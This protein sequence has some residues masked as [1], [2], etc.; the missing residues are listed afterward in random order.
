MKTADGL[1]A[2]GIAAAAL[3]K[4]SHGGWIVRVF[5]GGIRQRL[6]PIV[7][8]PAVLATS[9]SAAASYGIAMEVMGA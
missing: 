5:P 3:F 2:K 8:R 6:Q 1:R 4:P 9:L 7:S